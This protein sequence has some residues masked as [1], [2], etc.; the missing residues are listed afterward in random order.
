MNFF[1][2]DST[3]AR[4]EYTFAPPKFIWRYTI[5]FGPLI[6]FLVGLGLD[7]VSGD[8]PYYLVKE[9]LLGLLAGAIAPVLVILA[10]KFVLRSPGSPDPIRYYS[11]YLL[12][13]LGTGLVVFIANVL[14]PS[15]RVWHDLANLS[16]LFGITLLMLPLGLIADAVWAQRAERTRTRAIFGQYVS[17]SIA[18]RVLDASST[19]ALEGETRVATVLIS[20]IRGFTRMLS[21]LGAEQVVQTLNDYFTRMID[22]IGQYEGAVDKFIGDAIVVLYNAPFSQPDANERAIATAR[23]MQAA[24]RDLN[25]VRAQKQLPPLHIG[26][27]IDVGEVV[28]GNIGSPKRLQYTAIGAPVNTA[29]HLASLVPAEMIYVTEN[30]YRALGSNLSVTPVEQIELKGGTGKLDIYALQS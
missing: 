15:A 18:N 13:G 11:S 25:R 8:Y 16:Y 29:Y 20:D 28:C 30:V 12:A 5:I 6:G 24:L 19:A 21:E 4:P 10:R 7:A 26:I 14:Y 17:E 22:V 9:T 27:A 2:G 23:A 1:S 3:P